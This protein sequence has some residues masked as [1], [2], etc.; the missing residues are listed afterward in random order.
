MEETLSNKLILLSMSIILA[1]IVIM[2]LSMI[3]NGV[4]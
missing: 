4:L 3:Y 1:G 2:L